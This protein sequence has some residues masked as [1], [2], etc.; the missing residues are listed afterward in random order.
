[1]EPVIIVT[2]LALAQYVFFGIQ[3]GGARQKY[4]V[5]APAMSGDPQFD[6]VHRVHQNTQEQ[7]VVMLPALWLYA[8]YVNPLWGTGL[9]VVYLIGRFIYSAAYRKDPSTR[10][11]GFMLTLLPIV[12]MLAWVLIVAVMHYI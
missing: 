10:G 11:L 2:I 4:G 9:G 1:M 7:L 6:C 8:H 5:K 3:V 12:L